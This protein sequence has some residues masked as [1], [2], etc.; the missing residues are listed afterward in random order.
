M[1]RIADIVF[2]PDVLKLPKA[3][4]KERKTEFVN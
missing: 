2:F 3:T 1:H 4:L